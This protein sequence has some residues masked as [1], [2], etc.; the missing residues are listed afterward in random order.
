MKSMLTC[1]RWALACFVAPL[2]VALHRFGKPHGF[3][4]FNTVNATTFN[5]VPLLSHDD[6]PNWKVKRYPFVAGTGPA[7]ST[8]KPGYLVKF[9]ATLVNV[10]GALPADDALLSAVIIDLPDPNNPSDTSVAIALQGSFD[11]NTIKYAD[12]TQPINV[13]GV[14][15]LRDVGIFLDA[16]VPGGAFAP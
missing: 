11:K 9:D 6:D 2:I 3:E 8:M 4:A 5:P 1:V 13:A 7:L 12:G 10:T 15:Q 16:C 14:I